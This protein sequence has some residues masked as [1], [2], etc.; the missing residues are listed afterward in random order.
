LTELETTKRPIWG[1]YADAE[2]M[3]GLSRWTFFRLA[4][5]GH[6]RAAR[7]GGATRLDLASVEAFLEERAD[8]YPR[9]QE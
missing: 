5:G 4:K 1:S 8:E 6:I 9:S 7:I 3:F 2:R